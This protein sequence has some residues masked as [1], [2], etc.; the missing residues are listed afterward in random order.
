MRDKSLTACSNTS[1]RAGLL[2]YALGNVHQLLGE[3][4]TALVEHKLCLQNFQASLGESHHSTADAYFKVGRDYAQIQE[5]AN[6][7]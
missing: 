1:C 7:E 4:Q 3:F 2:R 5:Y 6:A